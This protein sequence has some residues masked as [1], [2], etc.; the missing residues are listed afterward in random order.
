MRGTV[1]SFDRMS[2]TGIISG[3]DGNRYTFYRQDWKANSYPQPG[4]EID[5]MPENYI[6][7]EIMVIQNTP[8]QYGAAVKTGKERIAY[9]LL[10]IFLGAF[11]AHNF[12][13]GY[14]GKAIAQLLITILSFGILSIVSFIWAIIE[15]ITVTVDSTGKPMT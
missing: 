1:I 8:V 7:K 10:G 11:G 14:N 13:A 15:V 5:F 4:L 2:N 9:I 3:Y 12:Y 6:A